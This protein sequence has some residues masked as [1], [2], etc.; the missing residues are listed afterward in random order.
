MERPKGFRQLAFVP[1]DMMARMFSFRA[2]LA[3]VLLVL[4]FCAGIQQAAHAGHAQYRSLLLDQG[5][6]LG[7]RWTIGLVRDGGRKGG[8]RPCLT[9]QIVDTRPT[10]MGETDFT[11][12][13]RLKS[14]SIISPT[15]RPNKVNLTTDE[16]NREVTVLGMVFAP[17]AASADLDFGLGGHIRVRLKRLNSVQMRNAGVRS[18]RY[19]ALALKGNQC[20]RQIKTSDAAGNEMFRSPID[21]CPELRRDRY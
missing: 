21:E 11:G 17:E 1:G 13:T 6:L 3:G 9:S 20:L 7:Y 18:L 10:G 15:G 12:E 2:I 16:G 4:A 5:T 8:Q 19:T 14:C